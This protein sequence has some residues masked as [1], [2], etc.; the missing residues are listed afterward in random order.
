MSKNVKNGRFAA[1]GLLGRLDRAIVC[2][3]EYVVLC[4]WVSQRLAKYVLRRSWGS[5]S[6]AK[7]VLRRSCLDV[8]CYFSE[9]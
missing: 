2:V 9:L 5:Q 3:A 7:Y 6:L 1:E 4:A 8:H